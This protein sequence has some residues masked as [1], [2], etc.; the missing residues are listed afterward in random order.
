MD[1]SKLQLK[2]FTA[3]A[4]GTTRVAS[5]TLIPVFHAWIKDKVL[6]ELL[7]DVA[8][9]GHVPQGP[10]VVL[11]GHGSDYA[12]DESEGRQGLLFN[13]KR[14]GADPAQRLEDTFRRTLHAAGL[15]EQN[16]VLAGELS[17]DTTEFLFR[18]NDRLAAP[19]TVATFTAVRPELEAF[20]ARL[21]GAGQFT[22]TATGEA[23]QLFGITIKAKTALPLATLLERAGGAPKPA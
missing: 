12:I 3:P 9:Y 14:L 11:I 20:C 16:S 7:L 23:R 13:R 2:I 10:G 18:I 4:A 15:L 21:F 19:N 1:A 6:P 17:F 8:N 22:L 5:E